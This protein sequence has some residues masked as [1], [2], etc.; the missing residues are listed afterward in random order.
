M[1][2]TIPNSKRG[3]A[4]FCTQPSSANC[5]NCKAEDLTYDI[6]PV[7]DG[8]M[9]ATSGYSPDQLLE[10]N[11]PSN[12]AVGS[13]DLD[14]NLD[15]YNQNLRTNTLQPDLYTRSEIIEPINS[16][17]GISFTQQW[18]PTTYNP[19]CNGG[20]T[21]TYHD[22]RIVPTGTDSVEKYKPGP[23]EATV[24]DPRLYGYGTS[25][26]SYIDE[27]TGQ[28]RFYYDDVECHSQYNYLTRS[29]IDFA[30]F[31]QSAGPVDAEKQT[32]TNS[33]RELAEKQFLDSTIQHRTELQEA[34]LRKYS[35]RYAQLKE[36][37]IITN[38]ATQAGSGMNG[39]WGTTLG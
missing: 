3:C 9:I 13:C 2:Y 12:K 24:Y 19:D 7:A 26:R 34:A 27:M 28:P 18:E 5:T 38:L 25:Y 21:Y 29:N 39:N 35:E 16:N 14:S 22:P 11:V 4:K 6:L 8:D 10:H 31:A 33:I 30:R 20:N 15:S 37:P 36:F 32:Y 1:R 23:T 17:I